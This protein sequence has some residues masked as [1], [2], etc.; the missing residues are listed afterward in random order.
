[1]FTFNY[2][3]ERVATGHN[4]SFV[5]QLPPQRNPKATLLCIHGFPDLAYGWRYQIK[6][7]AQAGYRVI[8][9]DTLGAHI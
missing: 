9:P 7:W 4:I 3:T 5:D 8:V 1:M 6:P 2:R